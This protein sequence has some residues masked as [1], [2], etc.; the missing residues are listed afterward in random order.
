M[1]L[2]YKVKISLH[3][4]LHSSLIELSIKYL[5]DELVIAIIVVYRNIAMKFIRQYMMSILINLR[6]AD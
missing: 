4:L 5:F 3:W 1:S 6:K 2:F